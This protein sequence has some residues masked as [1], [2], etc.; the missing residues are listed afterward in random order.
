MLISPA[1]STYSI[2]L[3]PLSSFHSLLR[4]FVMSFP[5]SP[6]RAPGYLAGLRPAHRA[7]VCAPDQ[8]LC[9]TPPSAKSPDMGTRHA[10]NTNEDSL[11]RW[12]RGDADGDPPHITRDF[13]GALDGTPGPRSGSGQ[14]AGRR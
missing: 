8:T 11:M 4:I 12:V 5:R 14:H 2:K 6:V 13:R 10:G 1:I 9:R 3:A 7:L